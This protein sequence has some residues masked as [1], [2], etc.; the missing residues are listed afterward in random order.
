M[1]TTT[2]N[3]QRLAG[4][5]LAT[6][7]SAYTF[8]GAIDTIEALWRRVPDYTAD[9]LGT[10]KVSVTPGSYEINQQEQAPR[11]ADF[12]EPTL[13]IVIAKSVDGE[14]EITQLEELVQNVVDAIRS[15]HIVLASFADSSDWRDIA[16]PVPF[17]RD[18]LTERNVFLA[19]ISVTWWIGV[20]KVAAPTAP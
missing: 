13:G 15:Y 20:E 8:P 16:V 7:L 2:T 6:A 4:D 12:F 9:D 11:G 19:Q 17:D 10:L 3:V 14:E 18:M 1:P 5:D